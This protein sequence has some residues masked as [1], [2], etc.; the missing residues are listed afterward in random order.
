MLKV[1]FLNGDY[2]GGWAT[3]LDREVV[4]MKKYIIRIVFLVIIIFITFT[5]NV[6]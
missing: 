2:T 1:R 4:V 5:K 6:K 3:S